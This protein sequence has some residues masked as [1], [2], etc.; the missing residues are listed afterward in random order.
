MSEH[1]NGSQIL[2]GFDTNNLSIATGITVQAY[3]RSD[4][5]ESDV[6]P[7][8]NGSI[9][10]VVTSVTIDSVDAATGITTAS[11]QGQVFASPAGSA[12]DAS[13]LT[14]TGLALFALLLV[15]MS[16]MQILGRSRRTRFA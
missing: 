1:E 15:A 8:L 12:P 5:F 11:V 16:G 13:S 7:Q 14:G 6:I 3:G 2:A 9:M 4:N 10:E